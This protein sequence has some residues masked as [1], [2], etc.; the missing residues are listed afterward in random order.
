MKWLLEEPLVYAATPGLSDTLREANIV[1]LV[2]LVKM[3]G[4]N[5]ADAG[6]LGEQLGMRLT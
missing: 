5:L 6:M 2:Q 1:T 4:S 3:V